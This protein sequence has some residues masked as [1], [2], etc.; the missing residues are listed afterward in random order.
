MFVINHATKIT[1]H[2]QEGFPDQRRGGEVIPTSKIGGPSIT[3][4]DWTGKH[5][6]ISL[7][8]GYFRM[9]YSVEKHVIETWLQTFSAIDILDISNGKEHLHIWRRL[10]LCFQ[11]GPSVHY[12]VG[13]S[14]LRITHVP[15]CSM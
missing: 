5:M 10:V 2:H 8:S 9:T 3:D 12:F 4:G 11:D 7:T 1:G 14:R 15:M 13:T 6:V